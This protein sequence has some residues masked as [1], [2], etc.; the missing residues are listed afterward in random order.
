M[1]QENYIGVVESFRQRTDEAFHTINDCTAREFEEAVYNYVNSYMEEYAPGTEIL[2]VILTGS[3]ARGIERPDSDMDFVIDYN[4]EMK[5][6]EMFNLLNHDGITLAGIKI[7]MNPIRI[8]ESG[9]LEDYLLKQEMYLSQKVEEY[10]RNLYE[11]WEDIATGLG[12][13]MVVGNEMVVFPAE[14]DAYFTMPELNRLEKIM[15]DNMSKPKV[16][17]YESIK[18][19]FID[20][21]K[22]WDRND[23]RKTF[24]VARTSEA[25][26]TIGIADKEIT[27]DAVKLNRIFKYHSAMTE[28][29]IM[30]LPDVINDPVFIL[31]SKKKESRIVAA[32]EVFDKENNPVVVVMELEPKGKHGIVLDEIKIASAYGKE[33]IQNLIA[34]SEML[35]LTDDKEKINSWIKCTGLQLPFDLSAIDSTYIISQKDE[36]ATDVLNE[37]QDGIVL[38]KDTGNDNSHT[39]MYTKAVLREGEKNMGKNNPISIWVGNQRIYTE[40]GNDGKW[41]ELPMNDEELKDVLSDISNGFRDEM[42]IGDTAFREDCRY[43]YDLIHEYEN[44]Q[45]INVVAKLL[46]NEPHPDVEMY[47][48]YDETLSMQELANLIV[49]EDE[50]P[51]IPYLFEGIDNPGALHILSDEEKLGYT[52]LE[53]STDLVAALEKLEVAGTSIMNY[54]DVSA[55]GRDMVLSGHARIGE[56]GYLDTRAVSMDLKE[57]TV[58]EINKDIKEEQNR[59]ELAEKLKD[60]EAPTQAAPK[61]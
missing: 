47:V 58:D 36:K 30:Q 25:M 28:D 60:V 22:T 7:D 8:E 4:G 27:L 10:E 32:G 17:G 3:R 54:I 20:E 11:R 46:G 56:E 1:E 5:E 43:L 24:I 41:I 39:K 61:L 14:Y 19:R 35:Y 29:V 13:P 42:Y 53:T 59:R 55:I 31:S 38:E 21:F 49:K 50:I 37:T 34:T 48:K 2:D 51:Y 9:M 33:N 26:G 16:K 15:I 23:F 44:I 40:G 12:Y 6:Y 52:V 45:E 57:Y 18:E